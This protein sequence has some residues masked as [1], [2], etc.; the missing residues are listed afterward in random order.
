LNGREISYANAYVY[1]L[2]GDA[3]KN[4]AK[5]ENERYGFYLKALEYYS[6][7]DDKRAKRITIKIAKDRIDAKDYK[8]AI[9]CISLILCKSE[10]EM[11]EYQYL[12]Y[13][14]LAKAN[15]GLGH[16][17]IAIDR[18]KM[19]VQLVPR[20]NNK[21][22]ALIAQLLGK[23]YTMKKE[24]SKAKCYNKVALKIYDAEKAIF[25]YCSLINRMIDSTIKN[26]VLAVSAK[27]A[28]IRCLVGD[29]VARLKNIDEMDQRK[30][31]Y[32]L[33]LAKVYR[34]L[35]QEV[36]AELYMSYSVGNG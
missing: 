26:E 15:F 33:K 28:E 36:E 19:A 4:E 22:R 13:Y 14:Y 16:F 20:E 32:Y 8:N 7:T 31:S 6:L 24:Y 17:D 35:E 18:S 3:L 29:L 27:K 2:L 1:E 11:D 12:I 30:F 21:D 5:Y 9:N 10:N 25:K 34:Y 23:C